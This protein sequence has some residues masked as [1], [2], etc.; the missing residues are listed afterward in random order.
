M[1]SSPIDDDENLRGM[2]LP[3]AESEEEI[4]A[5]KKKKGD[6]GEGDSDSFGRGKAGAG[7]GGGIK[8]SVQKLKQVV[9][10]WRQLDMNEIMEAV[11]EFFSVVLRASAHCVVGW[12]SVKGV[13]AKSFALINW[14]IK[15]GKDAALWTRDAA[16]GAAGGMANKR[17]PAKPFK[18]KAP[19][20]V[21]PIR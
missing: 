1:V 19:A 17:E 9:A 13:N 8:I 21:K 5:R 11:A 14:A 12:E 10:E 16:R 7:A 20:G 3:A 18:G 15:S 2:G 6:S 4:A